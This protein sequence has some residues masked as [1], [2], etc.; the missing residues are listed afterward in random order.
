MKQGIVI[1]FILISLISISQNSETVA[2]SRDYEFREGVFLTLG[3]FK[4][5]SPFPKA[6]LFPVSQK[7]R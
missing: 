6:P 3:Q 1:L 4:K 2:Y 5:M 7:T